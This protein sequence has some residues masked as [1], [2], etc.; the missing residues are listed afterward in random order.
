MTVAA[1]D[2]VWWQLRVWFVKLIARIVE[3]VV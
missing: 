2:D 3:I 1:A